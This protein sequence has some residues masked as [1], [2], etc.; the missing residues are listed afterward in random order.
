MKYTKTSVALAV[1]GLSSR[2]LAQYT[3]TYYPGS[4]PDE[5]QEGQ[6]GTNQCGTT[7]S[8]TSKCQNAFI[9][10]AD[11][12]C[13]WGP[14][15]STS[16]LGDGTNKIGNVE[17]IVVS[18]CLKD[19]Y[20]TRIIPSGTLTGAHFVKVVNDQVSYVQVTGQGD[21]TK[22]GLYPGDDGGELDPHSW[23]G[24]GNPQGGVVFTNAFTGNYEQTHEWT[25]FISPVDFC[26]RACRDGPNAAGWC[27]HIYDT[28]GC[29]FTI[30]GDMGSG[31]DNCDSDPALQPGVYDGATFNQ[32]DPTTPAPHP[33]AATYQCT[34]F[35]SVGGGTANLAATPSSSASASGSSGSGSMVSSTSMSMSSASSMSSS[36]SNSSSSA[37]ITS[38]ASSMTTMRSTT[39]S[40]A[41]TSSTSASASSTAG[42]AS[43]N[44]GVSG[45]TWLVAGVIGGAAAMI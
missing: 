17:E 32:G 3:A 41:S 20:G 45:L 22:M 36:M 33:A 9:N 42:S 21:M 34:P 40:R 44:V 23:T 26:F 39:S 4:E 6:Y 15:D 11:D 14:P 29:S 7:A 37:S 30:P 13:L 25:S 43:V 2:V 28:L 10:S 38:R 35:A 19:G 12:F 1:I 8:Q 16:P 27:E 31:F 5:T 18:Y 24:L